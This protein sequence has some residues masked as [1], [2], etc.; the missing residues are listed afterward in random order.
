MRPPIRPS[1]AIVAS[2]CVAIGTIASANDR[3][4]KMVGTLGLSSLDPLA[5][6][7]APDLDRIA[8]ENAASASD[9]AG[10][11]AFATVFCPVHLQ[12]ETQVIDFSRRRKSN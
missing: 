7:V 9:L 8:E 11:G 2:I 10:Q 4:E 5:Q 1:L 3:D 12:L 6:L